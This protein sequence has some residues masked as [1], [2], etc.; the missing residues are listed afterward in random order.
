MSKNR[1]VTMNKKTNNKT[2]NRKENK[3][4]IRKDR[5]VW[6]EGDVM[7]FKNAKEWEKWAKEERAR[8]AK[9]ERSQNE[10]K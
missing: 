6:E 1:G 7:I 8:R 4:E 10:E 9:E 2:N 5:F 3:H